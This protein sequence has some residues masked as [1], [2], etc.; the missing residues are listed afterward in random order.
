VDIEKNLKKLFGTWSGEDAQVISALPQ[1]GSYRTYYRISG[2]SQSAIGAT[3]VS[4]L[5]ANSYPTTN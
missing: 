2:N 3:Q 4:H 5:A 1:S